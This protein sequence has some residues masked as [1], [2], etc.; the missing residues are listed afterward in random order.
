MTEKDAVKLSGLAGSSW[1]V[2]PVMADLPDEF[3]QQLVAR[4]KTMTRENR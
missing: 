1:W 3:E 2:V 4:V